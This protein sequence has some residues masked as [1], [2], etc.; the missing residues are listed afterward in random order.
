MVV[1]KDTNMYNG[2]EMI[3][4]CGMPVPIAVDYCM[5]ET[6]LERPEAIRL[7]MG[8]AAEWLDEKRPDKRQDGDWFLKCLRHKDWWEGAKDIEGGRSDNAV[9]MRMAYTPN[10]EWHKWADE[11]MKTLRLCQE[12]EA[13][14]NE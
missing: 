11:A 4:V 3:V 5:T 8:E 13:L 10:G 7:L 2:W 9:C 6:G 1:S 14:D 12:L